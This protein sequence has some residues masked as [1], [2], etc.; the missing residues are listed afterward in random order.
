[1]IIPDGKEKKREY[2][3]FILDTC[4]MSKRD[5]RDLY[6]KRRLY[7]LFGTASDLEVK[8][9]RIESHIDLVSSF[10][11]SPD[12]AQF[13]LSA[14]LN[15]PDDQV[16]QFMAAEDTLNQDFRDAG[17]FELFGDAL[18]WAIVYDAMLLKAGWSNTRGEASFSAVNPDEFGVFAEEIQDLD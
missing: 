18:P 2:I 10:L 12:H 16:K 8:Y 3:K 6:D 9:N 17:L 1:M 4:L 13:S 15:S 11:Y 7:F 14:P 5:R